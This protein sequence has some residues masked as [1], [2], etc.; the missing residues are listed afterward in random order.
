MVCQQMLK[1]QKQSQKLHAAGEYH[2][3]FQSHNVQHV[4]ALTKQ[5]SDI[6]SLLGNTE[7]LSKLYTDVRAK[8]YF[9]TVNT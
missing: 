2:T 8:S 3:S 5:W 1:Q 7:I 4:E 6:A 9:T